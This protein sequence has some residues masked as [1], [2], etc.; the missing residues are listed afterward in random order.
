M[1]SIK[2]LVLCLFEIFSL[3]LKCWVRKA[4]KEE[5][6]STFLLTATLYI[7]YSRWRDVVVLA[8]GLQQCFDTDRIALFQRVCDSIF[9]FFLKTHACTISLHHFCLCKFI[10]VVYFLSPFLL[11]PLI[12]LSIISTFAISL[13]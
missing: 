2:I 10:F 8:T 4:D 6:M 13:S 12:F 7:W 9:H 5:V 11:R 1:F 3:V